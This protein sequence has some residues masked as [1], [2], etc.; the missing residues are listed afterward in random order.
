ME[1]TKVYWGYIGIIERKMETAI[2]YWQYIEIMEE[3]KWKLPAKYTGLYRDSE[4]ENGNKTEATIVYHIWPIGILEE[5]M[6]TTIGSGSR[7]VS[8]RNKQYLLRASP[9]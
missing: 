6:G 1:T 9:P 2:V 5:K 8:T 4:K 3:K 7:R